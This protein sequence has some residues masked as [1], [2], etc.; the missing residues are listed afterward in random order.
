MA[1][2]AAPCPF[3]LVNAWQNLDRQLSGPDPHALLGH[4]AG[5]AALALALLLAGW[6]AATTVPLARGITTVVVV[7][8]LYLGVA[9]LLLPR[10]DGAWGWPGALSALLTALLFAA[11]TRMESPVDR[12]AP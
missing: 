9:A 2:A 3:L 6:V 5:A 10:Y 12:A 11:S 8:H 7:S 1:A 4:W